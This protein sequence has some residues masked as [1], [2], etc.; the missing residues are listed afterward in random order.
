[1]YC[2]TQY[3]L[4]AA[5]GALAEPEALAIAILSGWR[6]FYFCGG[7]TVVCSHD[8]IPLFIHPKI[9]DRAGHINTEKDRKTIQNRYFF[10]KIECR[11]A[12]KN[13]VRLPIGGTITFSS[14]FK[15][16]L[17]KAHKTQRPPTS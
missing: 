5:I 10:R 8:F 16:F 2:D 14:K 15:R 1:M 12:A 17:A 3:P 6:C 7:K 13:N 11:K 4:R 9:V